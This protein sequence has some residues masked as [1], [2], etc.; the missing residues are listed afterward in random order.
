M[1][2]ISPLHS[3]QR[4]FSALVR[5]D[6]APESSDGTW[7]RDVPPVELAVRVGAYQYAYWARLVESLEEDFPRVRSRMGARA[8]DSL[9]RRYLQIHPSRFSSVAEISR[10]FPEFLASRPAEEAAPYLAD[11]A[12]LEWAECLV[13]LE[14]LPPSNLAALG[15][16]APADLERA[17]MLV[18]PSLQLV[19][20]R[21]P[22]HRLRRGEAPAESPKRFRIAVFRA[23]GRNVRRSLD[24]KQ[25]ALVQ[26]MRDGKTLAELQA[27]SARLGVSDARVQ[28]WFSRWA[29]EGLVTGFRLETR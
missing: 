13:A 22:V 14:E 28:A 2:D 23:G 6:R 7:L 1:T 16:L 4:R 15:A 12:R 5:S 25:C 3:L 11:L 27:W 21:F 19:G 10:G 24:E 17:V 26:A 9:A 18:N 8:F 20:T 29:S